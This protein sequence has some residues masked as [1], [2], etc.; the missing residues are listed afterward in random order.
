MKFNL[1]IVSISIH[2]SYTNRFESQKRRRSREM[3][4]TS[5]VLIDILMVAGKRQGAKR[6]KKKAAKALKMTSSSANRETKELMEATEIPLPLVPFSRLSIALSWIRGQSNAA[7][8]NLFK[9]APGLFMKKLRRR[10]NW[11][12]P[13]TSLDNIV[14]S[15][16]LRD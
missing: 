12:S 5:A 10:W 11:R 16:P 15:F 4:N 3:A 9:L 6:K 2:P 8:Y 1:T 14:L 7:C 13:G